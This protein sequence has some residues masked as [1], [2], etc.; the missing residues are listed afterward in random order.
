M[1]ADQGTQRLHELKTWPQQFAA[2]LDGSKPY[3][4]RVDDRGFAVGDLLRLA[5]WDYAAERYTGRETTRRVTHILEP[6]T[7]GLRPGYVV[8][9]LA[10]VDDAD[11]DVVTIDRTALRLLL[12]CVGVN[13]A[14]TAAGLRAQVREAVSRS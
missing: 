1:S 11:A 14:S 6:G 9:S 7:F 2:L 4:V 3:E 5:E 8:L 10:P 12:E 13:P